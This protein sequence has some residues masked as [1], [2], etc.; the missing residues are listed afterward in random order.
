MLGKEI[1]LDLG[2]GK[3]V[4]EALHLFESFFKEWGIVF[5]FEWNPLTCAPTARLVKL[6]GRGDAA[7]DRSVKMTTDDLDFEQCYWFLGRNKRRPPMFEPHKWL[8]GLSDVDLS[9]RNM[10]LS[11][12][13]G[14]DMW[15]WYGLEEKFIFVEETCEDNVRGHISDYEEAWKHVVEVPKYE[16]LEEMKMKMML[17]GVRNG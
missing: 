15:K 3:D 1:L 9:L 13:K 8:L 16:S 4:M 6:K 14:F 11:L 10:L 2:V 5:S 12:G 17:K 7:G